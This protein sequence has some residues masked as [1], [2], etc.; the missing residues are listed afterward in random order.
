VQRARLEQRIP[1]L[2][3]DEQRRDDDQ[4]A[5]EHG[6][7]VFRLVVAERVL[8]ACGYDPVHIDSGGASDA[9]SFEL[10]GFACTNLADGTER[11]H[12][13][14]ERIS[15]QALESLLDIAITIVDEAAVELAGESP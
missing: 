13:P 5:L 15:V 10:A 6:G 7:K 3:E 14:G 8:Q 2:A 12:E 11:N 4:R 1:R 9:N